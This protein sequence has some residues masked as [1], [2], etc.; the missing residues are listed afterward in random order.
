MAIKLIHDSM[1]FTKEEILRRA[2]EYEYPNPMAVEYFL[3]DC[4]LAA[5]LQSVCGDLIL[6]GGAATQLHLPLEK[7]RGSKDI[8]VV[9]SLEIKDIAEIVEKVAKA[10]KNCAKFVLHKPKKPAPN[11]PLQTYFAHVP[12]KIDPERE[13]LEVKIDFLCKCPTLP[14]ETIAPV[15]TY[16]LETKPIKCSTAGALTGDKLL[17]LAEGSIGLDIE[18]SYPK[19]IHDVDALLE[20]CDISAK[21]M[22]DFRMAVDCLTVTEASYRNID[23][24]AEKVLR[25]VIRAM[26]KY[27]L[28]DM[29]GGNAEIKQEIESFQQFYINRSQRRRKD[30]WSTKALRIKFLATLTQKLCKGEIS[31]AEA[32]EIIAKSRA[33]EE[34]LNKATGDDIPKLR[35]QILG[36]AQTKIPYFKDLKGK[37]LPRV[38]W[39]ILTPEKI[40]EIKALIEQ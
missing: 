6:K 38:L 37:P 28:V 32:A 29:P 36:L 1:Y 8:D 35:K 21:F 11:L 26:D 2:K 22:G 27:S 12:S 20:S 39:Q 15:K 14:S 34:N 16:A 23:A 4:E 33:I 10:F 9:T 25:D 17:S 7:Q 30:E 3:W 40:S 31:N 5:Q 18:E 19:Q 13:E 24:T